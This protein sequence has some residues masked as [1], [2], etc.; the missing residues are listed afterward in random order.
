[1]NHLFTYFVPFSPACL[2]GY[3]CCVSSIRVRTTFSSSTSSGWYLWNTLWL[4]RAEH[5]GFAGIVS[6][7]FL[8]RAHWRGRCAHWLVSSTR[9][10]PAWHCSCRICFSIFGNSP[11]G[12]ASWVRGPLFFSRKGRRMVWIGRALRGGLWFGGW[13]II[14]RRRFGPYSFPANIS[15]LF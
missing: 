11:S 8:V 4:D 13:R 14:R 3:Y 5:W 1:M 6:G 12:I 10:R 2:F 7:V 15:G 9:F